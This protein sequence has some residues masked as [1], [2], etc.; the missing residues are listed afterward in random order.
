MKYGH[1][2]K[3]EEDPAEAIQRF[4]TPEC[5]AVYCFVSEI[6]ELEKNGSFILLVALLDTINTIE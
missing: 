5:A 3:H 2:R 6:N 4:R 1:H